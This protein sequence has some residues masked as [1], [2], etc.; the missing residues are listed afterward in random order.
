[1]LGH[2]DEEDGDDGYEHGEPGLGESKEGGRDAGKALISA[3]KAGDP[4]AV[5]RAFCAMSAIH[6]QEEGLKE[7]GEA[8]EVAENGPSD[9]KGDHE[10]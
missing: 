4:E 3:V 1:M 2:H 6:E 7:S 8:E 5:Y 10:E 9:D